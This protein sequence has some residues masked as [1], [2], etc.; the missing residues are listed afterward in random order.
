MKPALPVA[1]NA[2]ERSTL[3]TWIRDSDL[4]PRL[5]MR[6]H[7]I[8][9]AEEGRT[10]QSIAREL[11]VTAS[12]VGLWRHRFAVHG[13]EGIQSLAPHPHQPTGAEG[14]DAETILRATREAPPPDRLRWTTRTLA[15]YLG[16]SHMRVYR[17]WKDYAVFSTAPGLPGRATTLGPW[18]DLLG[19][20]Q[21]PP[22]RA[23]VF[24]IDERGLPHGR[25]PPND[26]GGVES[27]VL[28]NI[29]YV[30]PTGTRELTWTLEELC[31]FVPERRVS[32]ARPSDL[33][34]FLR[35]LER[36]ADPGLRRHLIVACPEADSQARL[37][38]WL[39]LRENF[40][41]E[42]VYDSSQWQAAIERFLR[43]WASRR[44]ATG[45]FRSILPLTA[46]LV[47][48]AAHASPKS[49]SFTWRAA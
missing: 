26:G 29:I 23:I 34:I 17:V 24:G 48:F 31:R 5:R 27:R 22:I 19:T 2:R 46:A 14:N 45:S 35:S 43:E 39:A 40:V 12:T 25:T 10:N 4:P 15:R 38:R 6:A 28:P 16:L 3:E 11:G 33:L 21:C 44:L 32:V 8:L 18:V 47:R 7:I 37:R 41:S 49:V 42:I 36:H 9:K 1:P 20:F 13:L 30:P